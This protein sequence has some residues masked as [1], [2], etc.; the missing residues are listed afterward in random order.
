MW[1]RAVGLPHYE[2]ERV[3][4]LSE[5]AV[6]SYLAMFARGGVEALKELRWDG[7]TSDLDAFRGTLEDYFRKNPPTTSAEAGEIIKKLTGI[8]RSPTQ[9]REFLHRIGMKLRK[10]ATIPAKADPDKQEDFKE[11]ELEPRLEE[12]KAGTRRVYFM[13]GAHFVMGAFIG[14]LWCFARIFVRSSSGRQ[15]FNVL[16]ALCASTR[17]IVTVCN[18][19]YV[20]AQTVC[21]L[22]GKLA[23]QQLAVPITVVLDNARYQHCKLVELCADTLGIELLFLPTYSPNLNLIERLW[24]FTKNK[25]LYNKY[26]ESFDKFQEAI[27]SLLKNAPR[28]HCEELESL[29]VLK[30]Q[31]L[32]K[33]LSIAV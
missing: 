26:Y 24:K 10:V 22:L 4:D 12:A 21:E 2:I 29:L 23:A 33:P 17:E 16:G 3:M 1:L 28:T 6:R 11:K 20:N 18:T 8:E 14:W 32:Q 31:T 5:N 15:R 13:D 30:F 19:G 7:T 27:T 25:V 9:V